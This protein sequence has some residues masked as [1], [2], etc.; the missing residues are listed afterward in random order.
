MCSIENGA[1]LHACNADSK[2]VFDAA[3]TGIAAGI[4]TTN[5]YTP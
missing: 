4:I 2:A 5:I 1:H 3:S